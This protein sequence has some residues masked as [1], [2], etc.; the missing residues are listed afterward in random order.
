MRMYYKMLS[1]AFYCYNCIALLTLIV[2]GSDGTPG[3]QS[4][5]CYMPMAS[6]WSFSLLRTKRVSLIGAVNWA[7]EIN[8][9]QIVTATLH[10]TVQFIV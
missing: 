5:S 1:V 2:C 8:G 9:V 4:V 3:A 10:D 6:I 7:V